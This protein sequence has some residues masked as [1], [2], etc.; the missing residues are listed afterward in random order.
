V[1]AS[2]IDVLGLAGAWSLAASRAGLTMVNRVSEGFGDEVVEANRH[3]IPGAWQIER[4]DPAAWTPWN[5]IGLVIGTPPC[6]AFSSL[7]RDRCGDVIRGSD[8]PINRCMWDLIRYAGRC[9]G[10]DGERGPEI[11]AF[12]SVQGAYTQGREL[13][14]AL[15][16][17]LSEAT[18]QQ[19]TITHTLMSGSTVGSAQMRHRYFAVFH[20]IEFGINRPSKE[21]LP[22]G[23]VVTYEDAIG[24]LAGVPL[25]W[26]PQPYSSAPASVYQA[27]HQSAAGVFSYHNFAGVNSRYI[28]IIEEVCRLGWNAGEKLPDAMARLDYHPAEMADRRAAEGKASTS[29]YTGFEWPKRIAADQPGYVL[30]GSNWY[31]HYDEAR[32][33]TI[34]ERS[35]LMGYPDSWVWPTDSPGKAATWIGKCAPVE[36]CEWISRWIAAA[37]DGEPGEPA[38]VLADRER[39]FDCTN[40]YRA[41]L[42]GYTESSPRATGRPRVAR[43]SAYVPGTV[44]AELS[45]GSEA[46]V[47]E[48]IRNAKTGAEATVIGF[49]EKSNQIRLRKD[50]G[51][52]TEWKPDR[53]EAVRTA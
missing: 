42:P 48:R 51:R 9:G 30:S 35:R 52:P 50:D 32:P 45:D 25:Q 12:E 22:N 17:H 47:G 46:K 40:D 44:V 19:Y 26:T 13:M 38:P 29:G 7:N 1:S 2:F 16:D 34:A 23:R 11:V 5:G 4:A 6:S 8:S 3:F 39:V 36:S 41:W 15:R 27:E 21:D 24:D 10:A 43:I 33:L 18:G 20:R 14:V 37:L 31:V 49:F 28:P 53:C